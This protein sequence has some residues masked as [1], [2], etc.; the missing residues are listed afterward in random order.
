MNTGNHR[1]SNSSFS[2]KSVF[3]NLHH[4]FNSIPTESVSHTTA[5]CNPRGVS[6]SYLVF[7]CLLS[8]MVTGA[9]IY[10]LHIRFE[11]VRL[12]Y[13][14]SRARA[15]CAQL[16]AERRELRLEYSSL[17]SPERIESAAREKLGME[18]PEHD[19]I[20][21]MKKRVTPMLASGRAR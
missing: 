20:I 10:H 11:G 6:Y 19:R 7:F 3:S 18:M 12:G 16:I 17:K 15:A 8:L 13:M 4:R 2:V 21:L 9:L 14:T 1:K 5:D